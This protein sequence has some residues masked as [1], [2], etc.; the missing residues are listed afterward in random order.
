MKK[1]GFTL[2]ELLV[3]ISISSIIILLA[4]SILSR[5]ITTYHHQEQISSLYQDLQAAIDFMTKEIRLAGCDPLEAGNIGF[6]NVY[7]SE[8][9]YD[10]DS[11]SIHFTRDIDSPPDGLTN[12]SNENICYYL[13]NSG[14]INKLGRKTGT[15]GI[16]QPVAENIVNL[17]FKYY[18]SDGTELAGNF[19]LND[20]RLVEIYLTGHTSKPDPISKKR[21]EITLM[22][23]IRIRNSGFY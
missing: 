7:D 4:Y 8:D 11:N 22:T 13:Y 23:A 21:K 9:R 6:V 12:N 16:T 18:K 20:I 3:Y 2:V 14:G 10:T 17:E 5:T 19:N 1:K 15:T